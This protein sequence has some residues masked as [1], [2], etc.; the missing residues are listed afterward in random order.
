MKIVM[1]LVDNNGVNLAEKLMATPKTLA[2]GY[3]LMEGW[4]RDDYSTHIN[5]DLL[6]ACELAADLEQNGLIRYEKHGLTCN[7]DI[8]KK[9]KDAIAKA[10]GIEQ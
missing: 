10:K 3:D 8:L 7:N 4:Y 5:A 6:A 9:Y 2:E 1:L